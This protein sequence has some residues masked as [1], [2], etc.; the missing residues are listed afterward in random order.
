MLTSLERIRV[1]QSWKARTHRIYRLCC[2]IITF[3]IFGD[4]S[5]YSV[6]LAVGVAAMSLVFCMHHYYLILQN[7]GNIIIIMRGIKAI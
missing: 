6:G 1:A 5:F 3:Y 7:T 2:T 4:G